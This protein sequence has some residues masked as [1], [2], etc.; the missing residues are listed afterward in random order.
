MRRSRPPV[1]SHCEGRFCAVALAVAP[2]AA[3]GDADSWVRRVNGILGM[4]VPGVSATAVAALCNGR[5]RAESVGSQDC[6]F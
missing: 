5:K 2:A 1:I 3:Q 6:F 4:N